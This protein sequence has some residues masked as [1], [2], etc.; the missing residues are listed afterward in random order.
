L[1]LYLCSY[2]LVGSITRIASKLV[3]LLALLYDGS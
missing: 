2:N 3:V 1:F